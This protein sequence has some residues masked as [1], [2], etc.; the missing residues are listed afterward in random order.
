MKVLEEL[1]MVML[2][3]L[4]MMVVMGGGCYR[5]VADDGRWTMDDGRWRVEGGGGRRATE[6]LK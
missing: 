1:V 5:T 4:V 6:I 3:D 2:R